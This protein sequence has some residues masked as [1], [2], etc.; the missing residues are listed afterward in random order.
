MSVKETEYYDILGVLPNASDDEIKKAYRILALKYHPDRNPDGAEKFTQITEAYNILSDPTKKKEYDTYGKKGKQTFSFW[1][2]EKSE[3]GEDSIRKISVSL[4]NLYNGKKL[5]VE[6]KRDI[7]CPECNGQGSAFA[8]AVIKCEQCKGH[9][10]IIYLRRVGFGLVEQIQQQC[11]TCGG[12]GEIIADGLKCKTC[13]A[14]KIT[15]ESK[16]LEAFIEKGMKDGDKIVFHGEGDQKPGV[17]P[18]DFIL[19]IQE[20]KHQVFERRGVD[21]FMKHKMNLT[22]ALCEF[23]FEVEHLDGSKILIKSAKGQVVKPGEVLGVEGKGMPY[24]EKNYQFGNLFIKF[25][26][27]FPEKGFLNEEK[28]KLLGGAIKLT[29]SIELIHHENENE[30]EKE[31][32]KQIKIKKEKQNENEN[33]NENDGV[34]FFTATEIEEEKQENQYGNSNERF[35]F[36]YDDSNDQYGYSAEDSH[37]GISCGQM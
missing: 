5:N 1:D 37:P 25:N 2:S 17:Y 31:K 4:E 20:E 35:Q 29:K 9:G 33:E 19:I 24:R 3:R 16:I 30:N 21:L 22:D 7:V 36:I 6:V 15:T 27:K 26:V 14:K 11:S 10:S 13:N 8:G 23:E 28:M 34:E 32:E 18:G 12:T